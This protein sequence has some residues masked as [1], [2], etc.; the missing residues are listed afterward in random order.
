M[1]RASKLVGVIERLVEL[2]GEPEIRPPEDPLAHVLWENVAY[3]VDDEQR[4]AAF[5]ELKKRSA[6]RPERIAA[7]SPAQLEAIVQQGGAV[8][9]ASRGNKLREIAELALEHPLDVQDPARALKAI[10]KFPSIGKPS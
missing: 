10:A 4:R 7:L 1:A 8:G 6:L 9:A 5:A 3:L 2:H